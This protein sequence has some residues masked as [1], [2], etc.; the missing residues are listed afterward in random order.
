[1]IK[2]LAPSI[3]LIIILLAFMSPSPLLMPMAGTLL[4]VIFVIAYITYIALFWKESA[5]D[6]RE[7]LHILFSGRVSFIVGIT[8]LSVGVVKQSLAHEIDPWL[9]TALIAMVLAKS[10]AR[11]Y[12]DHKN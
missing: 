11:I 3:A 10:I 2:S 9:V 1:M 6:E 12:S 5:K 7:E 8:F 4:V